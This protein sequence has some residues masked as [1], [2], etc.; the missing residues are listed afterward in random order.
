MKGSENREDEAVYL[1]LSLQNAL[2]LFGYDLIKKFFYR[3]SDK[4][5][6][7][8]KKLFHRIKTRKGPLLAS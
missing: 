5:T 8:N 1:S 4:A 6:E 2:R 7:Q 3:F